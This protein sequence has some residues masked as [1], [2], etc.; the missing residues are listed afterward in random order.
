MSTVVSTMTF[1]RALATTCLVG[2]T[3]RAKARSIGD[4]VRIVFVI[5][6]RVMVVRFVLTGRVLVLIVG[7]S[8]PVMLPVLTDSVRN[9]FVV[10]VAVTSMLGVVRSGGL[11]FDSVSVVSVMKTIVTLSCISGFVVRI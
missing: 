4:L 11:F 6:T 8:V 10:V 3:F 2:R 9:V 7:F 5:L 1:G